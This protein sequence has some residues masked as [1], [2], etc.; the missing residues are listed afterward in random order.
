M[1][2][3]IIHLHIIQVPFYAAAAARFAPSPFGCCTWSTRKP[4]VSCHPLFYIFS[5]FPSMPKVVMMIEWHVRQTPFAYDCKTPTTITCATC[6][7]QV[8]KMAL[9]MEQV[10]FYILLSPTHNNV[11]PKKLSF[12][13][14]NLAVISSN[15][16][17]REG[18]S[19]SRTHF[20][21]CGQI[22]DKKETTETKKRFAKRMMMCLCLLLFCM[23]VHV[24]VVCV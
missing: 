2:S 21:A 1:D 11:T 20:F 14:V 7:Q 15:R 16:F 18:L 24:R 5:I 17:F 19:L 6:T 23:C 9:C 13:D 8:S 3:F 12:V 22:R 4:V 10:F